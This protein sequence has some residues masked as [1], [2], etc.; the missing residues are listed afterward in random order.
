MVRIGRN[1]T[2]ITRAIA[3]LAL[4]STSLRIIEEPDATEILGKIESRFV[5]QLGL[6]WWWEAFAEPN[7]SC[8]IENA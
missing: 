8:R 5:T 2:E 4:P 7:S 1:R 3:E 6:R